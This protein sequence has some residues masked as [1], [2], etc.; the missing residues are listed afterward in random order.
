MV[1]NRGFKYRGWW[2]LDFEL[3]LLADSI[4]GE[5]MY[6]VFGDLSFVPATQF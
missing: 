4:I 3:L 2:W 1:G 5:K 6:F